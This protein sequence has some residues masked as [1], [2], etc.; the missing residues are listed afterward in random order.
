[1]G[2]AEREEID[3]AKVDAVNSMNLSSILI[4]SKTYC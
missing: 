4:L 2:G 1:M 3:G